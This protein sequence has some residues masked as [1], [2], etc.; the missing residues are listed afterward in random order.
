[1]IVKDLFNEFK[2]ENIWNY[3]YEHYYKQKEDTFET[4]NHKKEI[5][6]N[7]FI[8]IK[9][10]KEATPVTNNIIIG[11]EKIDFIDLKNTYKY[12]SVPLFYEQDIKADFKY[13]EKFENDYDFSKDSLEEL[14]LFLKSYKSI[15][16]ATFY[17]TPIE[18]VVRLT[19][20]K[21]SLETIGHLEMLCAIFNELEFFLEEKIEEDKVIISSDI[22]L[23]EEHQKE[24]CLVF[25]E[26]Y[27]TL[28]KYIKSYA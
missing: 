3:L 8:K 26:N 12:I 27:K 4:I 15:P 24:V 14:K 2:F 10:I 21:K 16:M 6:K 9:S 28:Y 13:N 17:Y 11:Y 1:M 20:D 19:I 25:I 18:D 22:E 7:L 23:T 5:C